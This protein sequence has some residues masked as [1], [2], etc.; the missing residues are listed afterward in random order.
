M[1]LLLKFQE[2][3][4]EVFSC[5]ITKHHTV[6]YYPSRCWSRLSVL[7][8]ADTPTRRRLVPIERYCGFSARTGSKPAKPRLMELTPPFIA[9]QN[10][11]VDVVRAL[12]GADGIQA[13]QANL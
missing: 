6:K 5:A 7:K 1:R 3:L 9:C 11:H 4:D 2:N 8:V 13:N 10:G 12:L